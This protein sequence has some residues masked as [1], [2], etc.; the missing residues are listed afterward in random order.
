MAAFSEEFTLCGLLTGA[1]RNE[2]LQGVEAGA[3]KDTVL[4]TDTGRAVTL[5][6]VSDQKPL[7][8]WT[9]KQGQ[10]VT[11]PAVFNHGTGEYVMVHDDKVIRLW[12]EG[13]VYLDKV[14]KATLSAAVRRIHSLPDHEP[15]VLFQGGYV[16][17]LDALLADPQQE[18]ETTL[19]DGERIIWSD[20][21]AEATRSLMV[22]VTELAGEHF[23]Y[24]CQTGP[25]AL[26]KRKLKQYKEGSLVLGFSGSMKN[27]TF[28][29]FILYSSGH[30]CLAH[31]SLAQTGDV[32]AAELLLQLPET[33]ERGALTVLDD[34]HIAT[35]AASPA[36]QKDCLCIW[37]T[38]FQTLQAVREFPQQTSTQLW[39]HDRK[40]YLVH[41]KSVLVLPFLCELSCLASAL[42]KGRN[43]Q[44]SALETVSFANWDTLV[45]NAPETKKSNSGSRKSTRQKKARENVTEEPEADWFVKDIQNAPENQIPGIVQHSLQR[46]EAADFHITAA[47]VMQ[48]L[49][50]RCQNDPRFS[51]QSALR[52]LV[53]TDVLSYSL[54]PGLVAI[55]LEKQDVCLLQ[56]CLQRLPDVPEAVICS[57]LKTFL[58]VSENHLKAAPLDT[59]YIEGVIEVAES[60]EHTEKQAAPEPAVVQNGYSPVALE[61]DSCDIQTPETLPRR[62]ETPKSPVGFKRA[63]LLNSVLTC[64]YSETF[65]LPH[66]KDLSA[67]QVILFLRYLHYLYVKCSSDMTVNPSEKQMPTANQIMD[68]MS[69]MLDA[70][71]TV[72]VMLPEA[73][74]LLQK[75]HKFVKNQMKFYSEL[76]KV[77][78]SLSELHRLRRRPRDCDRYSIQVLELY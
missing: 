77:E 32:L 73:K 29:L 38:K 51:P 42:G 46:V 44:T 71:F 4:I 64:P 1:G 43:E 6:K 3:E 68:W 27:E 49:I 37:N 47:K 65:L 10:S 2:G 48:A 59:R 36:K 33:S 41:G 61:E 69:L 55:S 8:S 54:C 60:P 40:M 14:F 26:Q 39:C 17:F 7:G 11:G 25:R 76:N 66:L 20:M 24:T 78:G 63:V 23:V 70:H 35:L 13:D 67:N 22:Y 75:L 12:K 30:V 72:V 74:K 31:L 56:L 28:S 52:L 18:V 19:Q 16:Q 62:N 21:F 45:G 57:C 9:V 53:Q 58:S 15:L 50:N 5:Y 34:S